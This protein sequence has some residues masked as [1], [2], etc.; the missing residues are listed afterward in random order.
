[1][2]IVFFVSEVSF[3]NVAKV[4]GLIHVFENGE[5]CNCLWMSVFFVF[6]KISSKNE[7]FVSKVGFKNVAEVMGFHMYLKMVKS[8]IVCGC[9]CFLLCLSLLI[10]Q[11]LKNEVP[12]YFCSQKIK[13]LIIS[14][15]K[16]RHLIISSDK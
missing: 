10:Q 12:H 16:I 7:L 6:A 3:G 1:M 2:R 13:R 14:S 8:A 5:K 11:C 4:M 9:L 15:E